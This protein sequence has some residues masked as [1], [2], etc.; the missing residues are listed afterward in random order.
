MPLKIRNGSVKLDGSEMYYAS[1]GS[2]Q[3][4]LIILPG[5]SDGLATV[6][7]KAL[8]LAAPYRK[9]LNEFT[10][11]MFSRKEPLPGTQSRTVSPEMK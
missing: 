3:K 7:G 10:V 1:F 5:L 2:G 4:K 9:Y 11:F 6:K 8:L